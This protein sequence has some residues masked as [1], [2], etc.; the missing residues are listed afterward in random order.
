MATAQELARA[1][2]GFDP[3][4]PQQQ[5]PPAAP[6]PVFNPELDLGL[7]KKQQVA[8]VPAVPGTAMARMTPAQVEASQQADKQAQSGLAVAAIDSRHRQEAKAKAAER[9]EPPPAEA[10]HAEPQAEDPYAP[11]AAP[12]VHVIPGH[13]Q[14]GTQSVSTQHGPA[15]S[16][17]VRAG[18]DA[19]T[20]L[21]LESAEKQAD[22]N[23]RRAFDEGQAAAEKVEAIKTRNAAIAANDNQRD[24]AVEV[25]M[26][27]LNQINEET[28]AQYAEDSEK[29]F[30]PSVASK[31]SGGL[32]MV[33]GGFSQGLTGS[34][35]NPGVEAIK[36]ARDRNIAQMEMHQKYGAKK[37]DQES[38]LL[39]KNIDR[40]GDKNKALIATQMQQNDLI[41]A[42]AERRAA[43]LKT[44][45]AEK[46]LLDLKANLMKDNA[47][48]QNDF[49]IQEQGT[50][51]ESANKHFVGPQV[52]GGSAAPKD[53]A[54]SKLY[55]PHTNGQGGY[56]AKSEKEAEEGRALQQGIGNLRYLTDKAKAIRAKTNVAERGLGLHTEDM[57]E[58]RS[59]DAQIEE[60]TKAVSKSIRLNPET[61]KLF[62]SQSGN[63]TDM[64]G[65][66]EK[67]ADAMLAGLG[68]QASAH[69]RSQGA[70]GAAQQIVR[71]QNGNNIAVTRG[72]A[73]LAAPSGIGAPKGFRDVEGNPGRAEIKD[74]QKK[75]PVTYSYGT[76]RR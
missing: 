60:Q 21:G 20:G 41:M 16:D 56:Y 53:D 47:K 28:R 65:H 58:L 31:I 14:D 50:I 46:G 7:A 27:R 12:P 3:L 45:E 24:Q 19:A 62:K 23:R 61:E 57:D 75:Q 40:F 10:A 59:L 67:A 38:N 8:T 55:V 68:A 64:R 29:V 26:K 51:A 11:Q 69:E 73:S 2:L 49:N 42:Q 39:Q 34:Q 44:D 22:I 33:L 72:T 13:W 52:V 36:N 4:A 1:Q 70:Q 76:S 6:P 15:V 66:P 18:Y 25:G 63:W 71:D 32:A 43:A 37:Y 9:G 54:R 74:V 5:P 17:D 48:L 30:H 35:T